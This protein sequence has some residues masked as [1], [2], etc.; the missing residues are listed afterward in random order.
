MTNDR[1]NYNA[2]PLRR[3]LAPNVEELLDALQAV[4]HKIRRVRKLTAHLLEELKRETPNV[5]LAYNLTSRLAQM[6][7]GDFLPAKLVHL[8]NSLVDSVSREFDRFRVEYGPRLKDACERLGFELQGRYPKFQLNHTIPLFIFIDDISRKV[9]V[10]R[11]TIKGD[12]SV[13]AVIDALRQELQRLTGE[14]FDA[15][16]FLDKLFIAYKNVL[17]NKGLTPERAAYVNIHEVYQQ[18]KTLMEQQGNGET[19]SALKYPLDQFASDISRLLRESRLETSEGWT[20]ELAPGRGKGKVFLFDPRVS[21]F[22]YIA[23]IAF[24][25][26]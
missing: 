11:K 24:R 18:L 17:T 12:I 26:R 20:V 10:H 9:Q 21:R 2:E 14:P 8:V 13:E 19:T 6:N 25:R 22:R 7:V 3:P 1:D 5:A 4:H 16:L 15:V 23:L